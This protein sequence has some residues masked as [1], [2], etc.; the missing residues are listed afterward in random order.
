MNSG[1]V[2][3]HSYMSRTTDFG[4]RS[5]AWTHGCVSRYSSNALRSGSSSGLG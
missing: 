4:D 2:R 1:K 5:S 3:P